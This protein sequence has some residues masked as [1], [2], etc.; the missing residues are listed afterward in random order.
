M[1]ALNVPWHHVPFT[2]TEQF[3]KVIQTS[4]HWEEFDEVYIEGDLKNWD[5]LIYYGLNDFIV[6]AAGTPSK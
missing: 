1:L 6:G 4:S 3:G 5:F 2:F